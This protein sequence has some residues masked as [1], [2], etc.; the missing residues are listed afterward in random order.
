M[1]MDDIK[2]VYFI[3]DVCSDTNAKYNN[4]NMKI[5]SLHAK[6]RRFFA[7]GSFGIIIISLFIDVN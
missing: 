2:I 7:A 5:L 1:C 3:H 4:Q 6:S